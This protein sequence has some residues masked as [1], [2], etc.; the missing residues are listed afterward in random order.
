M[1]RDSGVG[2]EVLGVK[3][4]QISGG[5]QADIGQRMSYSRGQSSTTTIDSDDSSNSALLASPRRLAPR[6]QGLMATI[7][8]EEIELAEQRSPSRRRNS[9]EML[10]KSGTAPE[11][12]AYQGIGY[13]DLDEY[14]V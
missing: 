13:D 4:M 9:S 6:Q 10:G 5:T 11:V 14:D 2:F 3:K 12:D 8:D 7:V 1:Q